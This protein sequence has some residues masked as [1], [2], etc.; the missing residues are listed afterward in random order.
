MYH[1]QERSASSL[2]RYRDTRNHGTRPTQH[3]PHE[4]HQI[5]RSDEL[6]GRWT[7]DRI[8]SHSTS[9]VAVTPR[10]VM[11]AWPRPGPLDPTVPWHRPL[12]CPSHTRSHSVSHSCT[13]PGGG[14]V[15]LQGIW[16]GGSSCC[17]VQ[18]QGMPRKEDA[19]REELARARV[20]KV[21][22]KSSLVVV[23]VDTANPLL[24]D[25]HEL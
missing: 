5:R 8:R 22:A 20:D 7:D 14:A 9:V 2:D 24:V 4:C 3:R 1:T 13:C 12:H 21:V 18:R 10:T 11:H 16:G 25:C 6:H 17:C 19:E 23:L 15:L